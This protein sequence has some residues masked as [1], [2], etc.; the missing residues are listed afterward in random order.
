[1]TATLV[2]RLVPVA[3]AD[4]GRLRDAATLRGPGAAPV[5]KAPLARRLLAGSLDRAVDI[6]A[7][8]ELRG[9]SLDAPRPRNR[10]ARSRYDRR[11]YAVAALLLVTAIAGK[12]LG[13]DDFQAYPT[14]AIGFGPATVAIAAVVTLSGLAPLR[15]GPKRQLHSADGTKR[16]RRWDKSSRRQNGF[17]ETARRGG[18]ARV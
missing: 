3:A 16:R 2:S 11:F 12:L 18:I 14:L 10:R 8:L 15:R 4:A 13:A 1:L 9:Y 7:T 17:D 5:G 6:A